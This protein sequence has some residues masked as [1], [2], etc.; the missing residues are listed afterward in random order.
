VTA[1]TRPTSPRNTEPRRDRDDLFLRRH[2]VSTASADYTPPAAAPL[3]ATR[4]EEIRRADIRRRA[5][6][7]MVLMSVLQ[8]DATWQRRRHDALE[9]HALA[10]LYLQ[11][12]G[13]G[14]PYGYRLSAAT[15]LWLRDDHAFTVHDRTFRFYRDVAEAMP[16]PGFDVRDLAD[17]RDDD[18]I[19]EATFAGIGVCSLDTS[20]GA[21]ADVVATAS[22]ATTDTRPIRLW[23][24]ADTTGRPAPPPRRMPVENHRDIPATIRIMLTDG[25]VIV[26]ERRGRPDFDHKILH[27]THTLDFGPGESPYPWGWVTRE[28][29]DDDPDHAEVLRWMSQLCDLCAQTD[30]ARLDALRR[31]PPPRRAH[32]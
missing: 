20:T 16:G 2:D 3:P 10:F 30:A 1:V 23:G 24:R 15:K 9:P 17:R 19:D 26:G 25:T 6:N 18:M 31:Q 13:R 4:T 28:Q 14:G 32:R 7:R 8:A 5:I 29:L 11:P 27:S 22:V 21:W 12:E